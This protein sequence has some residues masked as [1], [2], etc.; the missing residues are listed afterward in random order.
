MSIS[1]RISGKIN[2]KPCHD[3]NSIGFDDDAYVYSISDAV[4]LNTTAPVD[5]TGRSWI[6]GDALNLVDDLVV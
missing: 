2:R 5:V 1:F 3:R 6:I 4:Y